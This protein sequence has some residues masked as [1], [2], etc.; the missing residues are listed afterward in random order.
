MKNLQSHIAALCVCLL[1]GSPVWAQSTEKKEDTTPR[2]DTERPHWYSPIT[3]RYQPKI[4]PPVNVSNT[5]RVEG[6]IR[7]GNLYLSLQDAIALSIENN[8]DIEVQRYT[9]RLAETDLF[10]AKTGAFAFGFQTAVP[11]GASSV[12]A[13]PGTP[14]GGSVAAIGTTSGNAGVAPYSFDPVL[15]GTT[16]FAHITNPTNN[17]VV[18]GLNSQVL[19]QNQANFAVTQG[20]STGAQAALSFT[21]AFTTSNS[22]T[23]NTNP[24]TSSNLDL[25][26]TQHLLQGFGMAINNRN[27]RIATNNL[28][29][30]D[31]VFQQQVM[32]TA[33]NVVNLYWNLVSYVE[34]VKVAQQSLAYA[35]KLYD[36]N[37]KQVD[38]G[39]LA[40]IEIVRAEAQVA[41]SE[42]AL[43]L[44]QTNVLQQETILKNA[45]S[46]NGAS[47]PI[48]ADVHIIPTD[49]VVI[50]EKEP[51]QPIQD[52]YARA[53]DRRPD[54]S[55]ARVQIDNS[56]INLKGTRNAML[57]SLDLIGDVRNSGLTGT[58]NTTPNP[59]NGLVPNHVIDPIFLGGY[60]NLLTQIFARNFPN[61][62]IGFQ[63][64]VPL[65][66]RAAQANYAT[67][68]VQL[69]QNELQ[70]QKTINQIRVDV[71]NALIAVQQAR[72]GYDAAVRTRVL[73]ERTLDAEQKKFAL[74][75]STPF[76]IIQ[77]QQ[78]LAAAQQAEVQALINYALARAQMD[79]V[80]GDTLDRYNI[81][82]DEAKTGRVARQS[83]PTI[84]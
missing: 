5:T 62:S 1:V 32:N 81:Q 3:S 83:L 6:L 60:G 47:N 21:N 2:L 65:R 41:T 18:A 67:A 29:V 69:R 46:R 33:N 61:Y 68:S 56:N 35:Q 15:T 63:L 31:Y 84:P 20:F 37:R 49:H 38:I 9:F 53:L 16:S 78:A 54:L 50:P 8:I 44:A 76:F 11:V 74:G 28:K 64:N 57:P 71:Q 39:T 14:I 17:S 30:A 24:T 26:V 43:I 45:L 77:A 51:I 34:N 59:S 23:N 10:R 13:G 80:T 58:I 70:L 48:L 75:N 7:A 66:N 73:Q 40:P 55:Q 12:T 22:Y 36:D 25:S 4:V 42:Q 72:V 82:I 79:Q 52:L 19:G 27:I